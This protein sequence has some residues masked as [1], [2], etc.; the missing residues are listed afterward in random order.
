MQE[1]ADV[2]VGDTVARD[3]STN[4]KTMKLL[5]VHSTLGDVLDH[6]AFAGFAPLVLPWDGRAYDRSLALTEIGSL[7]PYHTEVD[8][9]TVVTSLNRMITNSSDGKRVFHDIYPDA[10]KLADP[11]KRNTGLFYFPRHAGRS[12]RHRRAG[13]RIC[14]CRFCP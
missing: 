10:D 2:A 8:P 13:R 7:L 4:A 6:P 3:A 12:L 9:A 1:D 5:T 14:L 11:A